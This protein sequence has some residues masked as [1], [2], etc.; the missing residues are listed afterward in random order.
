HAKSDRTHKQST[1][2]PCFP[3]KPTLLR[4]K[5]CPLPPPF[6][7]F[8]LA[9]LDYFTPRPQRRKFRFSCLCPK[10]CFHM[11][12]TAVPTPTPD[13][14]DESNQPLL[15]PATPVLSPPLKMPNQHTASFAAAAAAAAASAAATTTKNIPI[16]YPTTPEAITATPHSWPPTPPITPLPSGDPFLALSSSNSAMLS[17]SLD[18]KSNANRL[19]ILIVDDNPINLHI[20]SRTLYRHLAYVV[21]SIH[22]VKSGTLALELLQHR[23][24]DCVLLDIDMPVLSGILTAQHIRS[25]EQFPVLESNRQVPIIAVT[26][27]DTSEWKQL[28]SEVGMNGC[29]G[30]PIAVDTLREV[31]EGLSGIRNISFVA[32]TLLT[33]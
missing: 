31:M 8:S 5:S 6:L 14:D 3:I 25:S 32:A 10:L 24:F 22:T 30:K 15:S 13:E 19:R 29:V 12:C 7:P 21:Q 16:V 4:P 28:Y 23:E 26:T 9:K 18:S 17:S 11:P 2:L 33:P 1:P 20:L 27:N